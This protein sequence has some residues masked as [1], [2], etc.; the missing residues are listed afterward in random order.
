MLH[1]TSKLSAVCVA[2]ALTAACSGGGSSNQPRVVY[3]EPP[4]EGKIINEN[5][6]RDL[7]VEI[8]AV[9]DLTADFRAAAFTPNPIYTPD[10]K[11]PEFDGNTAPRQK[12][13]GPQGSPQGTFT[14][15]ISDVY[16][17]KKVY[18]D[19]LL[20]NNDVNSTAVTIRDGELTSQW[21]VIGEGN[22]GAQLDSIF[23]DHKTVFKASNTSTN[24]NTQTLN[25]KLVTKFQ[26][27]G[28]FSE[29]S[30]LRVDGVYACGAANRNYGI[31]YNI[32][33]TVTFT[34]LERATTRNGRITLSGLLTASG[35]FTVATEVPVQR[36][37]STSKTRRNPYQGTVRITASD[38]SFMLINYTEPS[39]TVSYMGT[40][41]WDVYNAEIRAYNNRLG[42]CFGA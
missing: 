28:T 30:T 38:G 7:L 18:A 15:T 1:S 42:N 23:N 29:T 13:C 11:P 12:D 14:E 24:T 34:S 20:T 9:L 40:M 27:I 21:R 32:N 19:C 41:T 8:T 5:N 3:T 33:E 17:R 26:R 2:V 25:G 6:V 37:V 35:T 22:Y 16:N 39:I 4:S 31:E 10:N 36:F